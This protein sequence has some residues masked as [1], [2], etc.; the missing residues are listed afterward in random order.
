MSVFLLVHGAWHGAWCWSD[1][2]PYLEEMGHRVAA[3][4]LPGHGDDRTPVAQVTLQAYAD[5]VCG[6]LDALAEPV[7]LVGHSMGGLVITQ[8]AEQRPER[9]KALVYLCAFLPRNGESL[10]QL[11][12]EDAGGLVLPNLVVEE[13]GASATVRAEAIRDAFYADCSDEQ[14]ALARSRLVPQAMAPLATPVAITEERFGHVPRVY[15]ETLRDRAIPVSLQRKMHT[16]SPCRA[17]VT[18]D[19]SHS[20]FFSAPGDLASVLAAV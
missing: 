10:L 2:V 14:V 5:R 16:A 6:A 15:I 8:A 4:D 1:V 19:T 9:V 3:I 11:A 7:I 18:L 13:D 12:Q 20:P 17:V